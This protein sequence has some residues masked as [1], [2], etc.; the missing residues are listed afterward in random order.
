MCWNVILLCLSSSRTHPMSKWF[1][2]ERF[3]S[4]IC[5]HTLWHLTLSTLPWFACFLSC[6]G[7]DILLGVCLG[8]LG[9]KFWISFKLSSHAFII[10]CQVHSA[11]ARGD[12]CGRSSFSLYLDI[13]RVP[14]LFA[15]FHQDKKGDHCPIITLCIPRPLSPS[16]PLFDNNR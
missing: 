12:G 10:S 9:W 8:Y 15:R 7:H 1:V 11:H 6:C 5:E 14:S 3:E 2:C 13:T 4:A 16:T